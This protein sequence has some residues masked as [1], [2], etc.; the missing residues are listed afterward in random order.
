MRYNDY[1]PFAWLYN[2]YWG[3]HTL[4]KFCPI[5]ETLL[6][7]ELPPPAQ[8]L[9][10][11]CGT[12]QLARWLSDLGYR[13]TGLDGSEVMLH[14]ARQNAPDAVFVPADARD[15][16]LPSSYQAVV[17][18][19]DSLN[20]ILALDELAAAFRNVY[21]VLA[22][23][24]ILFCDLNVCEGFCERAKGH[25]CTVD[26]EHACVV[27]FRYDEETGLAYWECA[28]FRLHDAWERTDFSLT[29]RIYAEEDIDRVLAQ[30]GFTDIRIYD[31]AHCPESLAP[32]SPGRAFFKARK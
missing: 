11:C 18:T 27:R 14:F 26:D 6:L 24:G 12:G 32:L 25:S 3:A 15:F 31:S 20:H 21:R 2:K 7:P 8:V 28:L 22:P 10:L 19:Y 5:V 16:T 1:D 29:Q 23:G 9:D 30:A 4:R 13:V 17:S